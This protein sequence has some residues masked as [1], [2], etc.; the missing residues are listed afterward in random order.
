MN[1]LKIKLNKR[2]MKQKERYKKFIIAMIEKDLTQREIA[3]KLDCSEMFVFYLIWGKRKSK[4]LEKKL[5][6]ILEIDLKEIA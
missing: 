2:Q 1:D 3:K 6:E 5:C 4:R